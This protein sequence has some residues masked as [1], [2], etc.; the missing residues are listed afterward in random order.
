[1]ATAISGKKTAVETY[2]CYAIDYL[3][4]DGSKGAVIGGQN[5]LSAAIAEAFSDATYYNGVCGYRV[6]AS[7]KQHCALC[8]GQG[9]ITIK[10]KRRKCPACK[11][12]GIFQTIPETELVPSK[13]VQ[14]S[15]KAS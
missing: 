6:F 12:K 1:M 14:M 13:H 9:E 7:F 5:T 8:Q 2:W 3:R 4:E 15:E 10:S 11:G